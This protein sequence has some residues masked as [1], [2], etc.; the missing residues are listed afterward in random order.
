[1]QYGLLKFCRKEHTCKYSKVQQEI[2]HTRHNH[3]QHTHTH[4]HGR[5]ANLNNKQEMT[6]KG[7]QTKHKPQSDKKV[8]KY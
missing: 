7:R 5:N 4:T 6:I 3:Y 8:S 2:K 1:M